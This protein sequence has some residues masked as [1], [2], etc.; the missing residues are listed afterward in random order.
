MIIGTPN[1]MSPEQARGKD[2]DHQTDIFSFGVV[3]YE[4]LSGSSPFAGETVSDVIAAVL[5]KEPRT[6]SDI[7]TELAEILNKTLQKDKK[8][9]YQTAKDLLNDLREVKQ[10]LQFREK[11]K[12][13]SDTGDIEPKTQIFESNDNRRR[14]YKIQIQNL[15]SVVVLPFSKYQHG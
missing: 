14:Q 11:L 2:V 15:K 1:Y 9:R 3:F 13:T 5:T 8:N 4:M 6:L 12:R 10:E 7:P